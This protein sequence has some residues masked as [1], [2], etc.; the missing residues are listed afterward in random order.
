MNGREMVRV[1]FIHLGELVAITDSMI[2]S[3][4]QFPQNILT[5]GQEAHQINCL[6]FGF[7]RTVAPNKARKLIR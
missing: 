7:K 5:Q 4:N 3:L 6:V 1:Y 2:P